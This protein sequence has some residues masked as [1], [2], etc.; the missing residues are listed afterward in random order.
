MFILILTYK[1]ALNKVDKYLDVHKEYLDKFY[2]TG[3][4][5]A[6]GRQNPRIGGVI[7]QPHLCPPLHLR[8][9]PPCRCAPAGEAYL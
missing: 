7:L 1:K 6:S 5:I 4:F 9:S 2:E 8:R 3:D